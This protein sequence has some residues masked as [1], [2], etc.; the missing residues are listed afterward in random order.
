MNLRVSILGLIVGNGSYN[1]VN[2]YKI[3]TELL[4]KNGSILLDQDL[5]RA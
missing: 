4:Q 2:L 5:D 1:L 3:S